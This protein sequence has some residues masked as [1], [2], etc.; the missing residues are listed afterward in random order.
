M[1]FFYIIVVHRDD[2]TYIIDHI[3]FQMLTAGLR[4][5][6]ACEWRLRRFSGKFEPPALGYR[7][8]ERSDDQGMELAQPGRYR[9]RDSAPDNAVEL[10]SFCLFYEKYIITLII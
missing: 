10:I 2:V 8:A 5:E 9:V 1:L 3:I 6:F 7:G 4:L